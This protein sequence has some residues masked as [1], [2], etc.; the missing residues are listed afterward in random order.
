MHRMAQRR[1]L[2]GRAWDYFRGSWEGDDEKFS[3]RR[4]AQYLVMTMIMFLVFTGQSQSQY[5]FYTTVTLVIFWGVIVSIITVQQLLI[6]MRYYTS[7]DKLLD[8]YT[9]NDE[10]VLDIP[11]DI[12]ANADGV[13]RPV[14]HPL[15][16]IEG[17]TQGGERCETSGEGPQAGAEPVQG[18]FPHPCTVEGFLG[19]SR[20]GLNGDPRQHT[21]T[22]EAPDRM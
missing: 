20:E 12:L 5:G 15:D 3:Y 1:N 10:E 14:E 19:H 16:Q 6:F 7:R 8:K 18:Q 13:Q 11:P 21:D 2:I 22:G 9:P 17:T 4:F